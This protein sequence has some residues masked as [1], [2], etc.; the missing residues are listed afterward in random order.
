MVIDAI[1]PK[2]KMIPEMTV[3]IRILKWLIHGRN[4][5]SYF[6]VY[7]VVFF[8]M[9]HHV[10]WAAAIAMAQLTTIDGAPT[11]PLYWSVG[12]DHCPKY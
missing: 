1:L 5:T 12:M 11:Q 8:I 10:Q 6:S 2:K 3:I 4:M 9:F 7:G